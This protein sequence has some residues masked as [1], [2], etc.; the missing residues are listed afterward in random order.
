MQ[1][2]RVEAENYK[3]GKQ[4]VDYSIKTPHNS[5]VYRKDG[6]DI[7]STPNASNGYLVGWTEAGDWLTY[8]VNVPDSGAYSLVAHVA[9]ALQNTS[10]SLGVSVDGGKQAKLQFGGT[11]G[12]TTWLDVKSDQLNLSAGNHT[13]RVDVLAGGFNFDFL[14]LNPVNTST[15]TTSTPT[16]SSTTSASNQ[17]TQVAQNYHIDTPSGNSSYTVNILTSGTYSLYANESASDQSFKAIY[18]SVDGQKRST[19]FYDTGDSVKTP[20]GN[21]QLDAGKHTI[22][23]TSQGNF[24]LNSFDLIPT[25]VATSSPIS[26]NRGNVI[27]SN[28]TGNSTY[29]GGN[30]TDTISYAHS[31]SAIDANLATGNVYHFLASSSTP[32]KIMAVGDSITAGLQPTADR[33]GVEIGGYRDK[34]RN[35]LASNGFSVN[36]V[37]PSSNGPDDLDKN[38]AGYP[39]YKINDIANQLNSNNILSNYQP[40][41]VLLMA[42]TNDILHDNPSQA[43]ARL[44]SLIDQ[45]TNQ[46]PDTQVLVA[47]I[48]PLNGSKTDAIPQAVVQ[49]NSL[50][51][52]IVNSEVA[53]NKNVSYVDIFNSLNQSDLVDG[54]H[55]GHDGNTKIAQTWY[56]GLIQ[57][58]SGTDKLSNFKNIIGSKFNDTI[59]AGNDNSIIDGGG[60]NDLLTS[61]KGHDTFVLAAGR[62]GTATINNFTDG[63]D[64][65]GLS[66]GLKF[67]QLS[68]T[69]GTDN[70]LPSTSI[71]Y[72]GQQLALLKGVQAS[73]ITSN[74]F[75][76]V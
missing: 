13:I 39:G 7:Q 57:S 29:T 75:V 10:M 49:Y 54:V 43:P 11:G 55:P 66:N 53:K 38:H 72:N 17:G 20:I 59:T 58:N 60:G 31:G 14:Q 18:V 32:L 30:G 3:S 34:L 51:P 48:P 74:D 37:G 41:K 46:L 62:Q 27:E 33:P 47:S 21:F 22:N 23:V 25:N 8:D 64:L 19:P 12:W 50:I 73:T 6:G 9:S 42:G 28:R 24:K 16:S 26:N 56:N 69:Q 63:K 65:L 1:S 2:I 40:D 45:I 15:P 36:F 67:D 61:G 44:T 35:L 52:G 4:G 70:S 76:Y 5:G 68:I 71:S